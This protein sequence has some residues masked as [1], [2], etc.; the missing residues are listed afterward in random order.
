MELARNVKKSTRFLVMLTVFL[1]VMS[2]QQIAHADSPV[3]ASIYMDAPFVQ[4]S[5]ASTNPDAINVQTENFDNLTPIQSYYAS[6]QGAD[7]LCPENIA[8]GM[9]TPTSQCLLYGNDPYFGGATTSSTSQ[10]LNTGTHSTYAAT[11]LGPLTITF[12]EAKKYVGFWWSAGSYGNKVLFLDANGGVVAELNADD[13][14]NAF[15]TDTITS[16]TGAEYSS[17]DYFGHP[18]DSPHDQPNNTPRYDSGEPF[19]YIHAFAPTGFYGISLSSAPCCGFEFDNLTTADSAPSVDGRLVF[20][21]DISPPQTLTRILPSPTPT[22][23]AGYHFGG[24]Y[25]DLALNNYI[26]YTG[27][28]YYPS[29]LS[30]PIYPSWSPNWINII[31]TDAQ[32]DFTC[33]D[34]G[35][36]GDSRTILDNSGLANLDG[37]GSGVVKEG[38]TLSG[39]NTVSDGSGQGYSLGDP[40]TGTDDLTL[41]PVWSTSTPT[42]VS[43]SLHWNLGHAENLTAFISNVYST[44]NVLTL[45]SSFDSSISVSN[46]GTVYMVSATLTESGTCGAFTNQ[47]IIFGPGGSPFTFNIVDGGETTSTNLVRGYCYQWSEDSSRPIATDNSS[48]PAS[49]DFDSASLTSAIL[50]LPPRISAHWPSTIPVDPRSNTVD[51]PAPSAI[52]GAA[53]IHFCVMQATSTGSKGGAS[54]SFAHPGLE[55]ISGDSAFFIEMPATDFSSSVHRLKVSTSDP[56][57]FLTDSYVLVRTVPFYSGA[58]SY[59][60]SDPSNPFVI[61]PVDGESATIKI[62]P[63]GLSRTLELPTIDL[64]HHK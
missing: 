18:G 58:T 8:V 32:S 29:S 14:Y 57:K 43:S 21:T 31:Y 33:Y 4:A 51:L 53:S 64:G 62:A 50:K 12:P 23:K 3:V 59:C 61:Q 41:Y 1:L 7:G 36:Y 42:P 49:I 55:P 17:S 30:D 40:Y 11:H 5:Y 56:R 37:C 39:W 26:G 13:I 25:S 6:S 46:P 28:I 16:I 10:P 20:V 52:S 48:P 54:L 15:S 19:V 22:T 24:W 35:Y 45:S 2:A 34:G 44:Q 60:D 38:Y 63:Y 47:H 27:D 9:V